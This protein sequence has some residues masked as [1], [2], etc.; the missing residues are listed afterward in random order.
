MIDE[1]IYQSLHSIVVLIIEITNTLYLLAS[2]AILIDNA[3]NYL[4]VLEFQD[5]LN[6]RLLTNLYPNNNSDRRLTGLILD[7]FKIRMI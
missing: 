4:I 7:Y 6:M 3:P 1:S 5:W 2:L